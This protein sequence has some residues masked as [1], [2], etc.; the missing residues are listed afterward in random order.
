MHSSPDFPEREV[1][2]THL[3]I[4]CNPLE[5]PALAFKEFTLRGAQGKLSDEAVTKRRGGLFLPTGTAS[6]AQELALL[7]LCGRKG[8]ERAI[9]WKFLGHVRGMSLREPAKAHL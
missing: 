2:C 7:R 3:L 6:R 9:L 4:L 8:K 1:V 5:K